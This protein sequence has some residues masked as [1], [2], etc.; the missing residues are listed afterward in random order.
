MT[1]VI[2]F[3]AILLLLLICWANNSWAFSWSFTPSVALE[4]S[5]TDNVYLTKEKRE[6]LIYRLSP[7]IQ[8]S[9]EGNRVTIDV[10]Y[11]LNVTH[12][13]GQSNSDGTANRLNSSAGVTVVDNLLFLDLSANIRQRALSNGGPIDSQQLSIT[14]NYSEVMTTR[15]SPYIDTLLGRNIRLLLRYSHENVTYAENSLGNNSVL[16]TANASLLSA[17]TTERISWALDYS[18]RRSE[19]N[20]SGA[21]IFERAGVMLTLLPVARWSVITSLGY[22]SNDYEA[23]VVEDTDGMSY[24]FG[25]QWRPTEVTRIKI[26]GHD[27]YY[28]ITS[29]VE[30]EHRSGRTRYA[31]NYT[32]E[33]TVDAFAESGQ[34]AT[35]STQN[36]GSISNEA[37]LQRRASLNINRRLIRSNLSL[38]LQRDEREYLR[39][40]TEERTHSTRLLWDRRLSHH[41]NLLIGGNWSQ[42][43][44]ANLDREDNISG[45][46]TAIEHQFGRRLVG[47]MK[48]EHTNHRS[49]ESSAEYVRNLFTLSLR[50]DL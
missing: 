7:G 29:T 12:F 11:Q 17:S 8:L 43:A 23:S 36:I 4:V 18:K 46:H 14:D 9:G 5:H 3:P 35:L 15:V 26:M 39:S 31:L 41:T 1:S 33:Y 34:G 49:T 50:L 20:N 40:G 45:V 22:E 48:Y 13:A 2:H 10:D 24:G 19:A 47:S 32:E 30:F 44:F 27:R 42:T 28:G 37:F 6:E 21:V 16:T 25:L 38:E